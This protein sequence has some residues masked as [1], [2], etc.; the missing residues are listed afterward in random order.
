MKGKEKIKLAVQELS[1][2]GY[3]KEKIAERLEISTS[4]VYRIL[5]KLQQGS[6]QWLTNL[7]QKDCASIYKNSLDGLQQDLMHLNEL[8]E[9]ESVQ[10]NVKLQLQIRREI[11][12]TR[13]KYFHYLL[14][15]PMVWSMAIFVK[16]NSI[17]ATPQPTMEALGGIS[18]A[19]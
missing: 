17:E 5:A 18:G 19:K 13:S 1:L 9:K 4:T 14:Q 16:H 11:I 2:S 8:L 6:N 15:G 12:N 10:E 7:A 3:S